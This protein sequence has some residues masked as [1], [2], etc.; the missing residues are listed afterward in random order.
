MSVCS[1]L[2]F[3]RFRLREASKDPLSDGSVNAGITPDVPATNGL[4]PAGDHPGNS[5]FFPS[6][7]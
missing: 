4:S 5:I 6:T 7:S 3:G 1:R 2:T